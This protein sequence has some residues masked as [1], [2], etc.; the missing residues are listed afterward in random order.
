[1]T[2]T[3]KMLIHGTCDHLAERVLTHKTCKTCN[4]AASRGLINEICDTL[5]MGRLI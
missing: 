1:M 5:A 2:R 3:P 4:T